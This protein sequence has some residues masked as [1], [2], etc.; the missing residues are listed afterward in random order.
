M[1]RTNLKKIE[2]VQVLVLASLQHLFHLSML[3]WDVWLLVCSTHMCW[4]RWYFAKRWIINHNPLKNDH[5]T[6]WRKKIIGQR[7]GNKRKKCRKYKITVVTTRPCDFMTTWLHDH[8][9]KTVAAARAAAWR[10]KRRG[11]PR[12]DTRLGYTCTQALHCTALYWFSVERSYRASLLK[13]DVSGELTLS[14]AMSA[15][16]TLFPRK[17]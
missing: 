5:F 7:V 6:L 2:Y 9:T 3:S 15:M 16:S 12:L 10:R 14:T 1:F 11:E 13:Q 4:W 8:M 17:S